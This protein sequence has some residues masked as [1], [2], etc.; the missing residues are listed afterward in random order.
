MRNNH[1]PAR[2]EIHLPREIESDQGVTVVLAD[3]RRVSISP[4]GTVYVYSHEHQLG[5]EDYSLDLP[6]VEYVATHCNNREGN[7][8][9][10]TVMIPVEHRH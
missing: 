9:H 6:A 2:H 4:S 1:V 5:N 3:G 8:G 7:T 10:G